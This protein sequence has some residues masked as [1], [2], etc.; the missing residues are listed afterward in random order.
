MMSDLNLLSAPNIL[1]PAVQ[2]LSAFDLLDD[3]PNIQAHPVSLEYEKSASANPLI[4]ADYRFFHTIFA[5]D[6]DQIFRLQQMVDQGTYYVHMLY[7]FRSVSKA[8]PAVVRWLTLVQY[9]IVLC[10][11]EYYQMV[12]LFTLLPFLYYL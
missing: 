12:Y 8:L 9:C 4:S 1:T 2:R 10:N 5:T 3:V 11:I 7:T 6:T